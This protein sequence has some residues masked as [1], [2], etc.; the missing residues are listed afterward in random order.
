DMSGL[1]LGKG[2]IE[3]METAATWVRKLRQLGY[4]SVMIEVGQKVKA[5]ELG[6]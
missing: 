3:D 6:G 1:E 2:T 4:Y 5:G